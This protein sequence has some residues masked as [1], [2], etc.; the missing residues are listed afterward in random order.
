MRVIVLAAEAGKVVPGEARPLPATAQPAEQVHRAV[1][2]HRRVGGEGNGVERAE[3]VPVGRGGE[4]N[5]GA[6]H[7]AGV[8]EFG[9]PLRVAVFED[10]LFKQPGD[11]FAHGVMVT[12]L[13]GKGE[14]IPSGTR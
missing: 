12:R 9:H 5:F 11:N 2:D 10:V 13:C 7:L 1:D 8:D 6:G 14:S 3:I 4:G